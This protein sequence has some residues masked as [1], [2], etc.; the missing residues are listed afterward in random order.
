MNIVTA[1]TLKT[2]FPHLSP[3][4]NEQFAALENLYREWNARINVI[5][6]KDID[7]LY[8]HHVLHSL[9]IGAFLGEIS[10][11]TRFVDIGTGGGF[12]GVPLAILYPRASFHL[13]DRIGKKLRVAQEVSSA[14]GLTNVTYQH[15]DVRECHQTFDFAVS[16]AVM[17]LNELVKLSA[18]LISKEDNNRYANGLICLKGG[19]LEEE[20]AGINYPVIEFPI[21]EFFKE[22]FFD[23]KKLVYVKI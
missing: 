17:K 18:R 12:P 13:V 7:N 20:S 6:R 16:R 19:D 23:T 2:Y 4:Q 10:D 11:G 5:S 14:L 22:D 15:G 9:A 21:R 3:R 8:C 1:E